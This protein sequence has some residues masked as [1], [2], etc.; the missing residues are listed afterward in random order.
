MPPKEKKKGKK[1]AKIKCLQNSAKVEK[2]CSDVCDVDLVNVAHTP[3]GRLRK[4][5]TLPSS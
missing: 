2:G 4:P 1:A 5:P 3:L